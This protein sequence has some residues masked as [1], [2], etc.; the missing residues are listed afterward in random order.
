MPSFLDRCLPTTI[1]RT[2][3][4]KSQT[5]IQFQVMRR[6]PRPKALDSATTTGP[7]NLGSN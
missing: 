4:K 5:L 1:G 7:G 6:Q 2:T 3:I